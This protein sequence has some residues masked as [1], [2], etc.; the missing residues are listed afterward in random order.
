MR[1]RDV[2]SIVTDAIVPEVAAPAPVVVEVPAAVAVETADTF[3]PAWYDASRAV[4]RGDASWMPPASLV[5]AICQ[6]DAI[7]HELARMGADVDGAALDAR[8][9][10]D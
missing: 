5:E 4:A 6:H 3:T 10:Y 1:P 2:A 7:R 8:A 9:A